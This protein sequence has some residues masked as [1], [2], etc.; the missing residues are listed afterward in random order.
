MVTSVAWGLYDPVSRLMILRNVRN[1]DELDMG[2]W[3]I[4]FAVVVEWIFSCLKNTQWANDVMS[5][6]K[7]GTS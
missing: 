1:F 3:M 6:W 5:C 7:V 4:L 2:I